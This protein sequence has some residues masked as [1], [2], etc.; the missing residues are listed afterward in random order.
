MSAFNPETL[1]FIHEHCNDDVRTLALK[2]GKYPSVDM[3]AAITQISGRQTVREKVPAWAEQEGILY[4][5]HLFG[6]MF[7]GI[8]GV[9]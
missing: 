7:V 6:T 2:T 4:P 8:D 5:V 3:P 9:S 1:A